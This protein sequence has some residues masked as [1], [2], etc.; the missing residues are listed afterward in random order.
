MNESYRI[1][2]WAYW[3]V[4]WLVNVQAEFGSVYSLKKYK[5]YVWR[6]QNF[7]MSCTAKLV[8]VYGWNIGEH[9][10]VCSNY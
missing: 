10:R 9:C 5:K 1:G 2:I 7:S 4:E 3:T 6:I 8:I